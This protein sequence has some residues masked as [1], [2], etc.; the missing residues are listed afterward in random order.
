MQRAGVKRAHCGEGRRAAC[1]VLGRNNCFS[2]LREGQMHQAGV[3]SAH[4]GQGQSA[5]VR[6]LC[7]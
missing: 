6:R 1:T 2:A 4:C 5:A 3:D 7:K